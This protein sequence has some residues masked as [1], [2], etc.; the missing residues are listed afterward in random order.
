M[1]REAEAMIRQ[2][3]QHLQ[4]AQDNTAAAIAR[5]LHDE[6]MNVNMDRNVVW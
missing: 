5:E 3:Y 6:I 1:R 2:L 4:V